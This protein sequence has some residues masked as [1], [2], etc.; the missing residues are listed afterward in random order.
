MLHATLI[1]AHYMVKLHALNISI[2]KFQPKHHNISAQYK[3]VTQGNS[4]IHKM[5]VKC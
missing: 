2:I 3:N 5:A 4:T 1:H